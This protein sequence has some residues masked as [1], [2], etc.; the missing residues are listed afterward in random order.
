M[1]IK[2]MKAMNNRFYWL[3]LIMLLLLA[4]CQFG[5]YGPSE[6]L[7]YVNDPSNGFLQTKSVQKLKVSL[8][9]RPPAYQQ[10]L[11]LSRG[12]QVSES[13]TKGEFYLL[14]LE[15]MDP[16]Q[17]NLMQLALN[18][19]EQL[20]TRQ[21]F[22]LFQLKDYVSLVCGGDTLQ[23]Q[24]H[25]LEQNHGLTPFIDIH[26]GFPPGTPNCDRQIIIHE[27]SYNTGTLKFRFPQH[28]YQNP[29]KLQ[30]Q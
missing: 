12:R 23:C 25:H 22:L 10:A 14:R 9:H 18:T 2:D 20:N 29:P 3:G 26:L 11:A 6:Y 5:S 28:I 27:L 13:E 7:A 1:S 19:P 4:A 16:E 17:G 15:G 21:Q 8:Q 30:I 24:F